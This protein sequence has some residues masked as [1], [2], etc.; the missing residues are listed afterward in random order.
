ML[1]E[2]IITLNDNGNNITFKIRQL[3]ATKQEELIVKALLLLA[4]KEIGDVDVDKL[5]ENPQGVFNTKMLFAALEKV[6][7]T[8]IKE[9]SDVLLGCCYRVVGKMEERCTPDTVDGFIEDFRTLLTLKKEAFTLSFDF[10]GKEG[11]S[12]DTN[13]KPTISIGK[14][15][16]M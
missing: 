13:S 7:F 10:F 8:K 3:P 4:N 11:N 2:K 16:K 9:I 12:Q 1:K 5:K 15:S 6:D 14:V